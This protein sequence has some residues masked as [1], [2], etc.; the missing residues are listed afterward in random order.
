MPLG[1][2]PSEM[3]AL[4]GPAA[5][6]AGL[7]VAVLAALMMPSGLLYVGLAAIGVLVG[8]LNIT[9][10]ETGPFLFS[11]IA[12]IVA[13]LGM[14]S[15]ITTSGVSIPNQLIALAANITVLVGTAA[16]VISI[17]AIYEMAKSR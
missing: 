14:Q 10:K 5:F 8:I 9:A 7:I 11:S 1:K 12:F 6:Y 16:I 2:K 17:R 3:M 13:A 15:L 4:V